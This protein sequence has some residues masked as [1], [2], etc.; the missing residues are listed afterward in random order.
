MI[1]TQKKYIAYIDDVSKLRD[2]ID[3]KTDKIKLL[4][5]DIGKCELLV[6]VV[7][8]FSAG[9][10][11]LINSFLGGEF[12]PTNLTPET[13]LATEL[14]Y[15]EK[16]YI[17]AINADDSIDI[18][19]IDQNDKLKQNASKY[20]YCKLFLN[21]EKLK[22]IEPLVLVDMP[23]FD[24]PQE[25]HNQAILN[26]LHR[27]IY[28]IVL[29]SV[30]DGNIT[31]STIRELEN[32]AEY[33]KDFSFCLSKV[34]LKGESDIT[35]VK[36]KMQEQL[37]D[38]FDF[39]KQIITVSNSGGAELEKILISVDTEKL[40]EKIFKDDLKFDYMEQESSINTTIATLK[41]SKEE[42][43]SAIEELK[44]SIQKIT[45][46]KENMINEAQS[47]Y[48]DK[49]IEDIVNSVGS[50]IS[51][52][53]DS[54]VSIALSGG[55]GLSREINEIVKNSLLSNLKNKIKTISHDIVDDFSIDIKDLTSS[56]GGFEIS[57]KWAKT[58]ADSTK[59]YLEQAQNGLGKFS[60]TKENESSGKLMKLGSGALKIGAGFASGV[61]GIVIAFLPEIISFLTSSAK[62]AKQKNDISTKIKGEVI[63]SIK[64]KL[65]QELPAIF[66]EQVDNI[67]TTIGEKYEVQ[68]RE[69]EA[70]I[71]KAQDEKENS[72]KDVEAEI[73]RFESTR[74]E[75]KTLATQNLYK[76]Q[77]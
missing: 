41:H 23:G 75:L 27:G 72:I 53:H 76:E 14:R 54:L 21:N 32:M 19:E 65:R 33:G 58:I 47:K 67:I 68:L 40:F 59:N 20:R 18:Y 12:L 15:S 24:S 43:Q 22:Q 48:S 46:K 13:A 29:T 56:L 6:P 17:E 44:N 63:P 9:K 73:T 45:S 31:K 70:E 11:T 49:G 39:D 4:K 77:I 60:N 10:S 37:Q 74:E 8:G 7:G 64:S 30:E 42:S 50:D 71:S 51:S 66:H 61:V 38:Y 52:N 35:K 62:A 34:N 28:F 26:Y 69:K 36:E 57:D 16:S 55:D 2:S 25:L 5:T 1:K 3:T